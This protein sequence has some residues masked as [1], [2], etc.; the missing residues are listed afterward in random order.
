[1]RLKVAND[2]Y[3]LGFSKGELL[4]LSPNLKACSL[5]ELGGHAMEREGPLAI[6]L[7]CGAGGLSLGL[8]KSGF[9][10]ILGVDHNTSAIATHRAQF[11][12]A[13]VC[14]DL[15]H[16]SHIDE[17]VQGLEGVQIDLVAGSPPCQPF[18]QAGRNKIRS[19]VNEGSRPR[20]DPRV[21]LWQGFMEIVRRIGPR[22][23]L[24]ENVPGM[25][26]GD[27]AS[28][29]R[30]VVYE[31][32]NLDFDVYSQVH[33]AS[34]YGVPQHRQRLIII[35]IQSGSTFTWPES[36]AQHVLWDAISDLP[37]IEAVESTNPCK[38]SM[39]QMANALVSWLREGVSERDI[40]FIYDHVS[41]RV[42]EDDL[43]AYRQMDSKTKY[44][45]LPEEVRRYR[46]DIFTDKY[47][48]LA[49]N[50]L[51]RT[52]T[53]HIA[54]DGYWYI[55]PE[56]H[57]TL[58][59]REAA[60]V[61]TFPDWFRF[62]GFPTSA[63]RQIGEAVPPL[64]ALA[65]GKSLVD[66]LKSDS[67]VSQPVS[68]TVLSKLLVE[69]LEN[70]EEY[71]LVA[72]WRKSDS[73]W[74]ILLGTVL[75]EPLSVQARRMYWSTIRDRWDRPAAF[76]EDEFR[77]AACR[78]L[79]QGRITAILS[80][81]ASALNREPP[82]NIAIEGL[83]QEQITRASAICGKDARTPL[84]AA[85]MRVCERVFGQEVGDSKVH[86]QLLLSRMIGSKSPGRGYSAVLEIGER[87]CQPG[88]PH[89]ASCPLKA[90]CSARTRIGNN[91]ELHLT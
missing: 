35:G 78:A 36:T 85:A 8:E 76:L 71:E 86:G 19:L 30:E 45:D 64:M 47:K 31:L 62:S 23:V 90:N 41:R 88:V 48:R 58:T 53:A 66:S 87:Y 32:E 2:R 38:Y 5:E 79:G 40:S 52:I 25:A 75:F 6:D 20:L 4:E 21:E 9:S 33:S 55:H 56:Q 84:T 70:T 14:M 68:T 26:L 77:E 54:K 1:M 46:D 83:S 73:L 81:I 63:Y 65:L 44:S 3:A 61:Q 82:H 39:P 18:S 29:F 17:I 22:A 59:I 10:V 91:N 13:S 43:V 27:D 42:R 51:S 15:S 37:P 7:F 72:P 34:K 28:V 74:E 89:C 57:R 67:R 50:E 12:G 24:I 11:G 60:R 69:W 49:K 80:R 16:P